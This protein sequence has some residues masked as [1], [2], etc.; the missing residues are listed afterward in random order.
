MYYCYRHIRLDKNEPFYI[1]IGKSSPR[2]KSGTHND[3]YR[4]AYQKSNRTVW[5]RNIASYGYRV[6][7]LF[8]SN[9]RREIL[10][11]EKEFI[12]MYGFKCDGGTLCNITSGGDIGYELN[13]E[14][15]YLISKRMIG[16]A[17]A[18]GYLHSE[19]S[20]RKMSEARK[21]I[22][23]WCK[24]K[25]MPKEFGE[26]I[27]KSTKGVSKTPIYNCRPHQKKIYCYTN[28]TV[29]DSICECVREFFGIKTYSSDNKFRV[30]KN[31]ISKVCNGKKKDYLGHKFKF[32]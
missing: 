8:E 15:K 21:G 5:W 29:Y 1:G 16:N 4:R 17:N 11:K 25:K 18:K 7:I 2:Y 10:K 3:T 27:S 32:V 6:D 31:N 22:T 14:Q 12:K 28:D 19:E 20:K 13:Q 26:K 9:S 23:P 30:K 24:G